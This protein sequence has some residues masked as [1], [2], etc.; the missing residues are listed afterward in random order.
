MTNGRRN[1]RQIAIA[2]C[3][4]VACYRGGG[5]GDGDADGEGGTVDDGA[6]DG[7]SSGGM[8]DAP[9]DGGVG[10]M[11]LRRLSVDEFD[12]TVRDLLGDDTRPGEGLLPEDVVDPF[13]NRFSTQSASRPLIEGLEQLSIEITTRL[14]E[15]IPRRDMVVGCQPAAAA[16]DACMRSF[17]TS[18]GRRALRRTLTDEEIQRYVDLGLTYAGDEDDFYA[19]VGV[20][21]RAFLQDAE[22]VYRVEI[23]TPTDE[24][25][26]FS[27]NDWEVATRLSYFVWGTMPSDELLDL[28]EAGEL[29]TPEEV[30]A[31]AANML[32]DD[33][34]IDR[35]DRFHSMWLGYY[36]LPHAPELTTAMRTETRM[37]LEQTIVQE[38]TDWRTLFT[39]TG[40]FVDSMLA[41]HYGLPAPAGAGFQWVEYGDS[42]RKGLLS[43]GSFLSVAGKFGD[44]SPTQRGKIIRK[45]LF[46]QD[47]PP[48]PPDVNIDE[49][50]PEVDSPCKSARYNM[51]E[52]D[53][54]AA[55]HAL[56]DPV[57]FGL[58]NYDQAGVYRA[59]DNGLPECTIDGNGTID[60][61]DFNGP[62]G[63]A[64]LLMEQNLLDTC[65]VAQVYEFAMGHDIA[66]EDTRY[67][68]DLTG[69]FSEG[70]FR[71]DTL[72]LDLVGDE[73]FL[74]RREEG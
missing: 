19:G 27:L 44:T 12:N 38:Q 22:F 40:T 24:E 50:P 21:V 26:V 36:R 1:A 63:L 10:I 64:D 34:A 53:G 61:N 58:E 66:A 72:M 62:D 68:E 8:P 69:A 71:F 11:G 37:L 35:I 20:V 25:G 67:V 14:L 30:R 17:I 41:T 59:T 51:T 15:D 5:A 49:P 43:H 4:L 9:E 16:D 48:P 29:G 2:S 6:D 23:G 47:I 56:L 18:F 54:C 74:Y 28:A 73:A 52:I 31:A 32:A 70:G 45:R 65:I 60:G 13:D 42:G 39:A 46:C 33:R 3:L 55:C 57:G 7:D